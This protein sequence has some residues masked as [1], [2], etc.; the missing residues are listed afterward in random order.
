MAQRSPH[1]ITHLIVLLAAIIF[2][3]ICL[4]APATDTSFGANGMVRVGVPSGFN[5]F[6]SASARQADGKLLVAGISQ[7]RQTYAFI[8]RFGSNGAIDT[9]FGTSGSLL[10]ALPVSNYYWMQPEQIELQADGSIIVLATIY[11]GFAL[12]RITASGALDTQFGNA[13]LLLVAD[14]GFGRD[15]YVKNGIRLSL[16]PD[17]KLLVISNAAQGSNFALRSRRFLSNGTVDASFGTNGERVLTGLPPNFVFTSTDLAHGTPDGGMTL[18]AWPGFDRGTY[19]LLHLSPNGELDTRF[20]Y[21]GYVSGYDLGRPGDL[22]TQIARTPAGSTVMVG[23][24]TSDSSGQL[25]NQRMLREVNAQGMLNPAFGNA[26]LQPVTSSGDDFQLAVLP[27]G[28][29]V[30]GYSLQNVVYL[31]RFDANGAPLASFGNAGTATATATGYVNV[32]PVGIYADASNQLTIASWAPKAEYCA[33]FCE[34][35]FISRNAD[36]VLLGVSAAG[37][38]RAD[39]GS[40]GMAVWNNP[41]YSNDRIDTIV[42]EPSGRLLLAGLSDGSDVYDALV[43]RLQPDGTLDTSYGNN[44]RLSPQQNVRFAG[45]VRAALEPDGALV[46]ATGTAIGSAG[47]VGRVSAFRASPNGALDG[48]FKPAFAAPVTGNA[49]VAL[50]T[51]P[52]GRLVYGT[53]TYDSAGMSAVLQ[54]T[55]ADGTADPGFGSGGTV[56]FPLAADEWSSQADLTALADGS[57]VFAVLTTKNLRVFKVDAGGTPVASFGIGGQLAYAGDFSSTYTASG[58]LT[59]LALADGG[60]LA[61][62]E[63]FMFDSSSSSNRTDLLAIRI[64]AN[65]TLVRTTK[66]FADHDYQYRRLVA[67]PDASVLIAG[68]RPDSGS[69]NPVSSAALYRLLP[70][71]SFDPS[72][73][74]GGAYALPGFS[75]VSALTL[76]GAGK[77]LVAG[78]D[79]SSAILMRFA[80][81]AQ[82]GSVP[83]QEY[84][85]VN[86]GHYFVTAGTGEIATIESGGAGPGW[87]RTGYGFRAYVTESGIPVGTSPVC[88]FY[89]TP[90]VGPNSHFYTVDPIECAAVKRD[91]GWTYEGVA[92]HLYTPQ[93]GACAAGLRPVYRAYNNR[94]AQHDSNHRYVTDA[95]LLQPL[96]AMGWAMEG[97]VFCAPAE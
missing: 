49:G 50:A 81:S 15:L 11:N 60:L 46:V 73:G 91:P 37:Q 54:Q 62:V 88:R 85:N 24:Q 94:H 93:N 28:G 45:I 80:L 14:S 16:Q 89:G 87:Q 55:L 52:D 18:V 92:F 70:D 29:L 59:L 43:S 64:S 76:D 38:A 58:A 9:S 36:A 26:G 5:D 57:V 96:Q 22:P 65:G 67:L 41:R 86:L 90:G 27:D 82:A 25:N 66:L 32:H 69:S 97:I 10:L 79:P 51:R 17:G 23:T 13:G 56:R 68:T 31:S 42:V 84:F 19:L 34:S 48:T 71:D 78:Q 61:A 77:L 72:F 21:G 95:A 2:Q 8:T 74:P 12:I 3:Q 6:A 20:G 7:D 83:V 53:A 75:S 44:G 35:H 4:A 63:E 1:F 33:I 40:G 30:T 47:T 39:F